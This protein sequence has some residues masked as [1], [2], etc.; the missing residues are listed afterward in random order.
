MY[1]G[2]HIIYTD[3]IFTEKLNGKSVNNIAIHK[4]SILSNGFSER[5]G[6]IQIALKFN[7]T[8]LT[9]KC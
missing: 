9:G 6:D 4:G 8:I 5:V 7:L 3:V 2:A 1:V